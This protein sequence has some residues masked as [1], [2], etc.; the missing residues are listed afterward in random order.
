MLNIVQVS[1]QFGEQCVEAPIVTHLSEEYP[2]H[3]ETGDY[4]T[5]RNILH[6]VQVVSGYFC[7]VCILNTKYIFQFVNL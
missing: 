6:G 1:R 5:P 4:A 7:R 3:G 2:V